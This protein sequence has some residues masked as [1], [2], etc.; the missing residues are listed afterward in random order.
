MTS[1]NVAV[2]H[3]RLLPLPQLATQLQTGTIYLMRIPEIS[4]VSVPMLC[5]VKIERIWNTMLPQ[6]QRYIACC[7]YV[8]NMMIK[9]EY[10]SMM[11]S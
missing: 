11:P 7:P 4:I 8:R 2:Q 10:A 5:S 9:V 1:A 6:Q 3:L